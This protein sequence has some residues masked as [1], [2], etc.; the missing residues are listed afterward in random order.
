M[1]RVLKLHMKCVNTY[2]ILWIINCSEK[3]IALE[4]VEEIRI[5]IKI[6]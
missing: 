3:K 5:G 1:G 4:D 6:Y 2:Q